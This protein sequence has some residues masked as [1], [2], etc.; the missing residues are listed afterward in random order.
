MF[1]FVVYCMIIL[2]LFSL[3]II[4]Y[5]EKVIY[6]TIYVIHDVYMTEKVLY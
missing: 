2:T 4:V 1:D 5:H 6:M 3:V